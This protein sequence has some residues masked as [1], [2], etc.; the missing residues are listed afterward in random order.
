MTRRILHVIPH[1]SRIGGYERQGLLLA[2]AQAARE[3]RVTIITHRRDAILLR[4]QSEKS[5]S[6][7]DENPTVLGVAKMAGKTLMGEISRMIEPATDIAHLHALDPFTGDF[8]RL[9]HEKGVPTICKIATQGDV[10]LFAGTDRGSDCYIKHYN[11]ST[12]ARTARLITK[13][14]KSLAECNRFIALNRVIADELVRAQ[15]DAKRIHLMPNAVKI[16]LQRAEI[17]KNAQH[18]ITIGRLEARKRLDVVIDAF[19]RIRA[20]HPGTTLTIVGEGEDFGKLRANSVDGVW[21]LGAVDDAQALLYQADVFVFASELE[22]CPNVLLEAGAAGLPCIAS[23]IPGVVEWFRDGEDAVFCEPDDVAGLAGKWS[24]MLRS[25]IE[26]R[27]SLGAGAR[28]Q[29]ERVAGIEVILKQLN[30]LYE[31]VRRDS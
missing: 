30:R 11:R 24:E 13:A 19:S 21:W 25:G 2:R 14:W 15:I 26:V 1:A 7:R 16:P 9:A 22:G 23:A 28:A 6:A 18:A 20:T 5:A 10:S 27:N 8:A 4:K 12:S 29:V 17:R 31:S 3:E